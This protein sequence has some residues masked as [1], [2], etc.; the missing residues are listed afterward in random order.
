MPSKLMAVA[1]AQK[2]LL[3]QRWFALGL[4]ATFGAFTLQADFL[5]GLKTTL[6]GLQYTSL[7]KPF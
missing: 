2:P 7:D 5:F 1:A 3:M 4:S 6:R